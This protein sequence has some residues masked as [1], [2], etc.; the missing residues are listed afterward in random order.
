MGG[1]GSTFLYVRVVIDMT[2]DV[3]R[4]H[5]GARHLPGSIRVVSTPVPSIRAI[6]G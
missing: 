2:D 3:E 4:S 1:I 5:G 6:I